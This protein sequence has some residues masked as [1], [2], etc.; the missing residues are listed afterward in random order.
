MDLLT[1]LLSTAVG[2]AV[3][4]S[5]VAAVGL[6]GLHAAD[7]DLPVPGLEDQPGAVDVGETPPEPG[8]VVAQTPAKD[9]AA[10]VRGERPDE[11]ADE[12]DTDTD[13]GDDIDGGEPDAN[14]DFGQRVAADARDGGVVGQDIATE[15]RAG[16]PAEDRAGAPGTVGER[17]DAEVRQDDGAG[18]DADAP[19]GDEAVEEQR[20]ADPGSQADAHRPDTAGPVDG[21]P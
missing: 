6:G 8:D 5:A 9:E 1:S 12:A 16:T 7:V 11:G 3:A 14:A 2:K 4:A 18:Q 13:G 17:Q 19:H 10:P 15:A 20:P 21:R